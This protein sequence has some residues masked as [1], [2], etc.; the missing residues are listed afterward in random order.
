MSKT[1]LRL[2][3][4]A[5]NPESARLAGVPIKRVS[6]LAWVIAALL[7]AATAILAAPGQG[8]AF[9]QALGPELLL[10]ARTAALLAGMTSLPIAFAAG[11]GIG[12]IQQVL[13]Q[14][15][16]ATPNRVSLV[17]FGLILVALV[18]RVGRLRRAT[19]DDERADWRLAI[20][21]MR[22]LD[23]VRRTVGRAG[24]AGAVAFAFVLP[25]FLNQ[26][27]S[28][29]MSR[30]LVFALIAVSLTILAGWS[31]QLSLGHVALV[32]VGT[33]VYARLAD[34]MSL[35]L[36][37]FVAGGDQRRRSPSSSV[38]PRCAFLGCISR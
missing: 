1:G 26:S 37:F 13:A 36:L 2:R 8:N 22:S 34:N 10:R 31:G 23:P 11:I 32:A 35:A 4:T 3:A 12:V 6:T 14:N 30:V 25:L 17:M 20:A 15:W 5:E 9:T 19:A 24:V 18:L 21:T 28:L 16:I 27:R 7:S 33:V 38:F 29:L